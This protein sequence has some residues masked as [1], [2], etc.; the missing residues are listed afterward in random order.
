M[1]IYTLMHTQYI[2]IYIVFRVLVFPF[3]HQLGI[4]ILDRGSPK[5]M[6]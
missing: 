3:F 2:Y 6:P 1:H 5:G 4:Y